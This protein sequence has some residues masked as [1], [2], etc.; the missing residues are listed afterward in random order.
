MEAFVK[1][2]AFGVGI[3]KADSKL[4]VLPFPQ[5]DS[6]FAVVGEETGVVGAALLVG[7]YVMLLWRGL[8]I[9]RRAPDQLGTLLASGL[10]L[11]VVH[12]GLDQ[13]GGDDRAAAVCRQCAASDERGRFKPGCYSGCHGHC[14]K[15]F[16]A[17]RKDESRKGA[18]IQCGC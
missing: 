14:I 16:A 15:C 7:L 1:G 11:W 17:V 5:T 18:G 6:I 4:T 13:H 8:V 9:A 12:G 10:I 2:G 3:G